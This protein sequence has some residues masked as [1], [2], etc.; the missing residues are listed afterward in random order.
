MALLA[1]AGSFS[2]HLDVACWLVSAFSFVVVAVSQQL[3]LL[4]IQG[5]RGV[6]TINTHQKPNGLHPLPAPTPVASNPA[7]E[8]F[9][10]FFFFF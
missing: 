3:T 10:F 4:G 2:L 9:F 6:R 7:A 5:E 8:I 1:V